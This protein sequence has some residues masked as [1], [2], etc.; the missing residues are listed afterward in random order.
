M[1]K[2]RTFTIR[3]GESE[4]AALERVKSVTREATANKAIWRA[5]REYPELRRELA[6][7]ENETIRLREAWR[8]FAEYEERAASA[9]GRRD[10]ALDVCRAVFAKGGPGGGGE[11]RIAPAR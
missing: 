4:I 6:A 1:A 10:R 2:G 5:V 8:S 9:V 7:L 11:G 3:G